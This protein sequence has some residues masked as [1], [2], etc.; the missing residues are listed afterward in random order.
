MHYSIIFALTLLSLIWGGSYYF[1]KVLLFDFGPWSIAFLRSSIGL[2]TITVVM[3]ILK[4]PF[5]FK[6]IPWI[7]MIIM[8]LINTAIPWAL[9]GYSETKITSSLASILN[10]TTPLWTIVLGIVFFKN[11]ANL[12]QWF[13]MVIAVI[14]IIILLDFNPVSI[15]SVDIIGFICM[16]VAS[17]FYAIGAHLSKRL[18]SELSM[19]QITFGTLLSCMIGSGIIAFSTERI[20]FSNLLLLQN[21]SALIGLGMFGS[22]IAYILF[23]YIIQKGSPEIATMVTYLIPVS[24][25][26]WGTLLLNEKIKWSLLMGLALI[27]CGIFLSSKNAQRKTYKKKGHPDI[28][29]FIHARLKQIRR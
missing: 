21:V 20:S 10:A 15:V 24:G 8:A 6:H 4:K 7:P 29:H 17:L 28:K 13:S 22:G 1:I 19:Y 26:M 11:K 2:V 14:G 3:I 27:L 18:S 23:Y 16:I 25:I 9:I 12:Y 5:E